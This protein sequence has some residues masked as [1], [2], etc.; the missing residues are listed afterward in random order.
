MELYV[1]TTSK[2]PLLDMEYY[3]YSVG[4]YHYNWHN[5]VELMTILKGDVE[6]NVNGTIHHLHEDDIIWINPR[7]GHTTFAHAPDTVAFVIHFNMQMM[8]ALANMP[9]HIGI[10]FVAKADNGPLA[11]GLRCC[12]AMLIQAASLPELQRE[13]S[14]V[15][16]VYQIL[17]LVAQDGDRVIENPVNR[18]RGKT[19]DPIRRIVQ[20][21]DKHYMENISLE[22]LGRVGGYN[23]NYVSQMFR[24]HL[25]LTFYEYVT[26]IRLRQALI[27]L[28]D[29][30]L[31]ILEVS[32]RNGFSDLRA[33][34]RYFKASFSK[35]PLAYRNRLSSRHKEIDRVFKRSY[36][37][38]EAPLIQQKLQEYLPQATALEAH[39]MTL[40]AE[41]RLQTLEEF[42][43]LVSRGINDLENGEHFGSAMTSLADTALHAG[44]LFMPHSAL[45]WLFFAFF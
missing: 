10:D 15:T 30:D 39:S 22:D 25:G 24:K 27:D 45:S 37:L 5:Q 21:I 18:F 38:C 40:A 7:E 23:A 16:Y 28:R 11:R 31:S 19:E 36:I 1:R 35:T 34:N 3:A 41:R 20:Y 14:A 12:V 2:T 29:S 4:S 8:T 44:K 32:A 26:R 43:G 13:L 33:F 42:V 6:V 9:E 17:Q